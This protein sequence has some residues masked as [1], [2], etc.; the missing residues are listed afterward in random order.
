MKT[1]TYTFMF[2]GDNVSVY[3]A[4]SYKYKYMGKTL[5]KWSVIYTI[6]VPELNWYFVEMVNSLMEMGILDYRSA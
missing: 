5:Y 4:L 6:S 3:S 2:F 1:D